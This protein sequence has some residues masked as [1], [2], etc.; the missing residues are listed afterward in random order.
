M[1]VIGIKYKSYKEPRSLTLASGEEISV[2]NSFITE[3]K[4]KLFKDVFLENMKSN[5]VNFKTNDIN[6]QM[7]RR[8]LCKTWH[9]FF[10]FFVTNEKLKFL[11][12]MHFNCQVIPDIGC[13]TVDIDDDYFMNM[14]QEVDADNYKVHRNW[15]WDDIKK[16]H[17][18]DIKIFNSV[19]VDTFPGP[20]PEPCKT[21]IQLFLHIW[22]PGLDQLYFIYVFFCVYFFSKNK[23]PNQK[24]KKQKRTPLLSSSLFLNGGAKDAS[25]FMYQI[26]LQYC[27]EMKSLK[28][29]EIDVNDQ[30]YYKIQNFFFFI[31]DAPIRHFLSGWAVITS[32]YGLL[33]QI[34]FFNLKFNGIDIFYL[35]KHT[36]SLLIYVKNIYTPIEYRNLKE[37]GHLPNTPFG[38]ILDEKLNQVFVDKLEVLLKEKNYSDEFLKLRNSNSDEVRFE[39]AKTELRQVQIYKSLPYA[40]HPILAV[41][42]M[43]KTVV[44]KACLEVFNFYISKL[45]LVKFKDFEDAFKEIGDAE[46]TLKHSFEKWKLNNVNKK[47]VVKDNPKKFLVSNLNKRQSFRLFS[48]TLKFIIDI[49]KKFDDNSVHFFSAWAIC[50]RIVIAKCIKIYLKR[51]FVDNFNLVH[52]VCKLNVILKRLILEFFPQSV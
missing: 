51:N 2:S 9:F 41:L 44:L 47:E 43:N 28:N 38:V 25:H 24:T 7:A 22:N 3:H 48:K 27:D 16:K 18:T 37:S 42:H 33:P 52:Q 15:V 49:D 1:E 26:Y 46:P 50:V 31:G 20:N 23:K 10:K 6:K 39:I 34:T 29:I 5:E 12:P 32:T 13:D 14:N 30:I 19:S 40:I 21:L 36:L 4:I 8:S 17:Y 11:T 45:H 35:S